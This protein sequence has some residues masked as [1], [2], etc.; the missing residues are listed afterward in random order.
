MFE[1]IK[2]SL[3]KKEKKNRT[4]SLTTSHIN[5]TLLQ[6]ITYLLLVKSRI[7]ERL[8]DKNVHFVKL[9]SRSSPRRRERMSYVDGVRRS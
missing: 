5:I 9:G 3:P 4:F 2:E 1:S 7:V 8:E 6:A